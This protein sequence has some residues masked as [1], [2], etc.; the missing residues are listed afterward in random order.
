MHPFSVSE[1]ISK[2]IAKED[3]FYLKR[4]FL[5]VIQSPLSAA[6][7]VEARASTREMGVQVGGGAS[8]S[9]ERSTQTTQR[10]EP[11]TMERGTQARDRYMVVDEEEEEEEVCILD[12][13]F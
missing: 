13:Y 6:A 4:L 7:R 10:Q 1:S 9:M 3:N 5:S 12:E 2:Y 11:E 8:M